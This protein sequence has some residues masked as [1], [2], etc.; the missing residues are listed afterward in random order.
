MTGV[1]ARARRIALRG[2][3]LRHDLLP[4]R[5]TVLRDLYDRQPPPPRDFASFGTGS[6]IVPPCEVI[7]ADS[8]SVGN[9]VVVLEHCSLRVLRREP[10]DA[11]KLVLGDGVRLT[12]FVT[13][14][15]EVGIDIGEHV[16]S[17]DCVAIV[18]TWRDLACPVNLPSGLP[19]PA[20]ARVRIDAG[21]YLG[22]GCM[23][24]PGV[25]VGEGAFVGEGAVV[26]HDVP[27]HTVV[28][29]N[30]ARV[31]RRHNP[32]TGNWEGPRWP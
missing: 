26:V 15:C 22:F 4:P 21:A 31:V 12:R 13:I 18:D 20:G 27:A 28:Y 30:P 14:V 16:A 7:G 32:V 11:P 6:W 9:N 1:L 5:R 24:G 23:V 3:A 25:H 10:G 8:I 2:R 19:A 17:S 29:G